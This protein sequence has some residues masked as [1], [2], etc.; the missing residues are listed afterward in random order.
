MEQGLAKC[1]ILVYSLCCCQMLVETTGVR[2]HHT[3]TTLK[4]QTTSTH[5]LFFFYTVLSL[6]NTHSHTL[7]HIH[8]R[9][10]MTLLWRFFPPQARQYHIIVRTVAFGFKALWWLGD[11]KSRHRVMWPAQTRSACSASSQHD[12]LLHND[13]STLR[14]LT[15]PF[16]HSKWPRCVT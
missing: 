15:Y 3:H 1:Q 8:T 4:H 16:Q 11:D 12:P 13:L 6:F 5:L 10:Q 7:A 9:E 2:I 14:G